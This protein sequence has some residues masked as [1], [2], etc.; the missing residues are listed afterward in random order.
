MASMGFLIYR[1]AAWIHVPIPFDLSSYE[2]IFLLLIFGPLLEEAIFRLALW[3]SFEALWRNGWFTIVAT[4]FLFAAG[5]FAAYWFVPAQYHGFVIYQTS[6]VVLLGVV[7]GLQRLKFNA[8]AP[9]I[10]VHMGFNLGFFLASR[11]F[12]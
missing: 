4:T 8:L 7:A 11:I 3:Q 10:S 12:S 5:H 1:A 2:T 9:A 6:Y